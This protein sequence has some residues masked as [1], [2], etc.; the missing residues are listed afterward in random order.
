MQCVSDD[1]TSCDAESSA[2]P[3]AGC[4]LRQDAQDNFNWTR[5]R[6]RTPS[7]VI[8]ERR[9]NGGMCPVTGPSS[10]EQGFY[11]LFT[12]ATG[13]NAGDLARFVFSK[14]HN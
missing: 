3:N 2:L 11:Y 6:D 9:I 10:A 14:H 7:G 13:R 5:Y 4:Q 12:E 1:V 8:S